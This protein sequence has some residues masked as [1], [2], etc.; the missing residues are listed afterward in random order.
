VLFT[1]PPFCTEEKKVVV[2]LPS[3]HVATLLGER[4]RER[5]MSLLKISTTRER[6]RKRERERERERERYKWKS[7]K[8]LHPTLR[9]HQ[10][11]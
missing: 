11:W 6:E 8:A 4:G 7:G 5:E 3:T 10:P 9:H 2:K 1:S